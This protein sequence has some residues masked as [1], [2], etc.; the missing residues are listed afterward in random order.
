VLSVG[1]L[2]AA[3]AAAFDEL[4]TGF[5]SHPELAQRIQVVTAKRVHVYCAQSHDA[6]RGLM[7][8]LGWGGAVR[9]VASEGGGTI[10]YLSDSTC[11]VLVRKIVSKPISLTELAIGLFV[12]THEA[13]HLRGIVDEGR[14]NCAALKDLARSARA[15]GVRKASN[16][17]IVLHTA[18]AMHARLP[19]PYNTPC[20]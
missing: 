17:E 15:F 4:P 10:A 20:S 16:V 1:L 19:P 13:E 5:V 18:D 3:P 12:L 14:A 7:S 6:W 8:R 11:D 9:A 2:W